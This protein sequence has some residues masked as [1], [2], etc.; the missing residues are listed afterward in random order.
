MSC[1]AKTRRISVTLTSLS[2][3]IICIAL[4]IAGCATSLTP[5]QFNEE[6]PKIT[7][8]KFYDRVSV[9]TA[10]SEG[11]CRLLISNRKYTAPIGM[12]VSS[13]LRNGARGI[14]EWVKSDSGNAYSVVNYEWISVGD[15]DITQLIVYFD[16]LQ[17]K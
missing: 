3:V 11:Q 4:L 8:A 16:T 10:I 14:D 13:D 5:S 17:C 1:C 7:S 9:G 15:G 2:S 12:T 6:L